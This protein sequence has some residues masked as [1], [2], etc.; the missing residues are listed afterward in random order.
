MYA[1]CIT[2]MHFDLK[3]RWYDLSLWTTQNP[4]YGSV[5]TQYSNQATEK[6]EFDK[7]ERYFGFTFK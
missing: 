4:G 6:E 5:H 1:Y 7:S 3:V 2:G